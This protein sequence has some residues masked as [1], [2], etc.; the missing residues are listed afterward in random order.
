MRSQRAI[1]TC[2]VVGLVGLCPAV[3]FGEVLYG[4]ARLPSSSSWD[5]LMRIDPAT[6]AGTEVGLFGAGFNLFGLAPGPDPDF[7]YAS[8]GGP[9]GNGLYTVSTVTGQATWVGSWGSALYDALAYDA[10]ND[11]LYASSPMGR[12]Y[13]VSQADGSVIQQW[14]VQG[15]A[16]YPQSITFNAHGLVGAYGASLYTIDTSGPSNA[17][18]SLLVATGG[19]A[20]WGLASDLDLTDAD[21]NYARADTG[22]LYRVRGS[23]GATQSVGSFYLADEPSQSF[24]VYDAAYVPVP[25]PSSLILLAVVG[26]PILRQ[27]RRRA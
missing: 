8:G 4:A 16:P 18:M 13:E 7:L 15:A 9:S 26:L 20:G 11:T 27:R 10:P 2:L 17:V 12:V 21:Y 25:E 23:D 14:Q 19:S 1:Q 6:A 3:S 22:S 5:R 24:S